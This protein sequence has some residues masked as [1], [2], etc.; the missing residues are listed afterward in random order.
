MLDLSRL[1]RELQDLTMKPLTPRAGRSGL[2]PTEGGGGSRLA[3]VAREKARSRRL[4]AVLLVLPICLLAEAGAPLPTRADESGVSYCERFLVERGIGTRRRAVRRA[5]EFAADA[6]VQWCAMSY[7]EEVKDRKAISILRR[8]MDSTENNHT[9][10]VAATNLTRLHDQAG[11]QVL[12]EALAALSTSDAIVFG[13]AGYLARD[14]ARVG[15]ASGY[16]VV[17]KLLL[18]PERR[19]RVAGMRALVSFVRFPSLD[20]VDQMIAMTEHEDAETRKEA[21]FLFFTL[22]RHGAP[23]GQLLKTLQGLVEEDPDVTVREQA[24]TSLGL[25]Q[26]PRDWDEECK[27][28]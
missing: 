7:L 15:D 4:L 5:A 12:R 2:V 1:R 18:A 20:A 10:I 3:A 14:L 11:M 6:E 26:G 22:C 21:A 17:L 23:R 27:Q 19:R 8:V 25:I 16:N 28:L 9:R 13:S 24:Q